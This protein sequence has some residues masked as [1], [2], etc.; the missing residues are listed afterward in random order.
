M[1]K[2]LA[3]AGLSLALGGTALAQTP[4]LV[5]PADENRW[6]TL[7]EHGDDFTNPPAL[8]AGEEGIRYHA[9]FGAEIP[10]NPVVSYPSIPWETPD[11][12]G[13]YL[14]HT[15]NASNG[16]YY[17]NFVRTLGSPEA[18]RG[19]VSL[20]VT[21]LANTATTGTQ[22]NSVFGTFVTPTTISGEGE[23]RIYL[24]EN[25][26]DTPDANGG[27]AMFRGAVHDGT[28]WLVT[29]D[30][31]VV[32]TRGVDHAMVSTRDGWRELNTDD[33][34][35]GTEAVTPAG[36]IALSGV[37][38]LASESAAPAEVGFVFG[39]SD[40]F[41]TARPP[42]V[43]HSAD[44]NEDF[45]IDLPELLRVIELYN[46]RDGSTRTGRYEPDA[47][48]TD[49]FA[50]KPDQPAGR[51]A[52]YPTYHSADFDRNG[53]VSLTE[54]L[55]LIELYNTREDSSR[56]GRYRVDAST[57]DGFGPDSGR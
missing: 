27:S 46:T 10:R 38:F 14:L 35:Y 7:R 37:W 19:Y 29:A 54:L 18:G 9:V 43:R 11:F 25:T 52:L 32:P 3:L 12:F 33:F 26:I 48:T 41:F 1:I 21:T 56:T 31:A 45:A 2:R 8:G 6:N 55:R 16:D 57:D 47:A 24:Y 50:P 4:I 13:G 42:P 20:P 36:E 17:P 53:A 22:T 28:R 40:T 34:T 51:M 5:F 44:S 39:F 15:T 23:F 30:A 49:G